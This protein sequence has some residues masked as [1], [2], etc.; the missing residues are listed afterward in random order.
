[1]R[2]LANTL[3]QAATEFEAACDCR[4]LLAA[5]ANVLTL[6]ITAGVPNAIPVHFVLTVAN[7]DA[8]LALLPAI[9]EQR[10]AEAAAKVRQIAEG[11]ARA[12]APVT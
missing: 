11:I 6:S 5:R 12:V 9:T 2:E 4:D 1:M 7:R 8:V 3:P 10:V